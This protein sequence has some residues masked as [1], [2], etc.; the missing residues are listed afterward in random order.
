MT[1]V[2]IYLLFATSVAFLSCYEIMR[3]A[4]FQLRNFPDDVLNK[5][6]AISYTTMFVIAWITAPIMILFILITPLNRA[7]LSGLTHQPE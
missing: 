5:N 7:M 1:G 3:V 4:L 6:K 2:E